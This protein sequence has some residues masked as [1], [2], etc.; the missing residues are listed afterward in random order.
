MPPVVMVPTSLRSGCTERALVDVATRPATV[1]PLH[2]KPMSPKPPSENWLPSTSPVLV[3]VLVVGPGGGRPCESGTGV[4]G[5]SP[6]T[7]GWMRNRSK[8]TATEPATSTAP[9]CMPTSPKPPSL[10][11][12]SVM[13][14]VFVPACISAGRA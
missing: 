14:P 7:C 2:W 1:T 11:C 9:H 4:S 3:A 10:N 5:D 12:E 6:T 13:R 8:P